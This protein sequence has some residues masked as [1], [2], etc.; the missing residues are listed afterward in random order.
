MMTS[1]NATRSIFYNLWLGDATMAWSL[2]DFDLQL[3]QSSSFLVAWCNFAVHLC[4]LATLMTLYL[5]HAA[6]FEGSWLRPMVLLHACI[7]G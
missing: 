6:S 1:L 4:L 7:G 5:S 3:L 2:W